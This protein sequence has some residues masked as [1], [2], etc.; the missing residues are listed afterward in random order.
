MLPLIK[1]GDKPM[2]VQ[3][4]QPCDSR[5]FLVKEE[6]PQFYIVYGDFADYLALSKEKYEP[7]QEWADVT[8][9]CSLDIN[10]YGT[11]SLF[12]NGMMLHTNNVTRVTAYTA[13]QYKVEVKR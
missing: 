13:G 5:Q 1:E 8:Q 11:Y 3:A 9:Q 2:K 10:V 6:T 4:K 7:V 12:L